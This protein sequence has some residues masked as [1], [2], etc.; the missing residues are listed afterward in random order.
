MEEKVK[1]QSENLNMEKVRNAHKLNRV[2]EKARRLAQQSTNLKDTL[3]KLKTQ[4]TAAGQSL[5]DQEVLNMNI[6]RFSSYL[7]YFLDQ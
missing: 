1:V 5:D 7:C 2:K 4:A 3:N 6:Q